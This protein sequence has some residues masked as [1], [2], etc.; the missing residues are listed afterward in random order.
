MSE[1]NQENAVARIP[2]L[3]R[4]SSVD[5]SAVRM[6]A[7]LDAST[8]RAGD[9][10][11]H[12]RSPSYE[13]NRRRPCSSPAALAVAAIGFAIVVVAGTLA[14]RS[15][16]SSRE[17]PPGSRRPHF[18]RRLARS[19]ADAFDAW[20]PARAARALPLDLRL[21]AATGG[22]YAAGAG[23]YL[24][25]YG[26]TLAAGGRGE[27]WSS[28]RRV[29]AAVGAGKTRREDAHVRTPRRSGGWTKRSGRR[30]AVFH[31]RALR[32]GSTFHLDSLD[33]GAAREQEEDFRPR[34]DGGEEEEEGGEEEEE[35]EEKEEHGDEEF[36]RIDEE[37]VL[38]GHPRDLSLMT[39]YKIKE[40]K[41]NKTKKKKPQIKNLAPS[42][43]SIIRGTQ[44]F[45]AHVYPSEITE[46]AISEVSFRLED[47]LGDRSE[48]MS[49]P[50][51]GDYY[52]ITMQ[53]FAAYPGS[54]WKCEMRAK[55]AEGRKK[56]AAV[57]VRVAAAPGSVQENGATTTT[58]APA[59]R[60]PSLPAE[61]PPGPSPSTSFLPR[62]H[63]SD[64]NWPHKGAIQ[65]ATGRIMFEFDDG[66]NQAFVCSGTVV[67]DGRNS[68][69]PDGANGR[70][71]IATAAHCAYN[72]VLKRF[73]S[74]AIF[75]PDQVSTR[76][77]KS[78]FDCGDDL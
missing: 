41:N 10:A 73:A 3:K 21:D 59:P 72:D 49:V 47:E 61:T 13:R 17:G 55:D 30:E 29:D 25:P 63:V 23:G 62:T 74:R 76:G 5:M 43:N 77:T 70:T 2:D 65:A 15:A 22:A 42:K 52:E 66:P 69:T 24:A 46:A 33:F 32:E 58:P 27:Y 40:R 64:S 35:E 8:S 11:A 54:R 31:G 57:K 50:K 75:I 78:N 36:A 71:I 6:A 4:H 9:T 26:D 60:A 38:R 14:A 7:E 67:M 1:M 51:V 37:R 19:A 34:E 45:S 16:L 53:G 44:T 20:T 48:W 18:R 68:R 39:A 28:M 12:E 56:S